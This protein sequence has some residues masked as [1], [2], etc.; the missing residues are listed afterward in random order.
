[1]TR[2]EDAARALTRDLLAWYRAH[3]RPLPWRLLPTPYRVWVGE[4]MSQQTA[5]KVAVGRFEA[6]VARLPDVVALAAC[7]EEVLRRL[8]AGLGYYARARN[9]QKGARHVIGRLSGA[10]PSTNAGWL[11][12]P[13]CGPYTAAMVASMCFGERVPAVDGNVLRVAARVLGVS[14]GLFT[15]AGRALVSDFAARHVRL[16]DSAGDFN[17]ALMELGAVVCRKAHPACGACPI[18]RGCRARADGTADRIPEPRPRKAGVDTRVVCVAIVARG[19]MALARRERGFLAG[20]VGLPIAVE[21]SRAARD[22][23]AVLGRI[24]GA[25]VRRAQGSFGHAITHHRIA[26]SLLV[27]E[28]PSRRSLL[29]VGDELGRALGVG[30]FSWSDLASVPGALAAALDRKALALLEEP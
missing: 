29:A 10:L 26:G 24:P 12:I 3:K 15:P 22:A 14:E 30:A 16:A 21:G 5:L 20:T 1:L 27:V 2:R 11:E 19:C 6:F 9:L 7:D 8:W 13:G 18:G 28:L 4:V 25:T 23:A 17:Q